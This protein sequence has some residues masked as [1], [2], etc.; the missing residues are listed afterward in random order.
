[1]AQKSKLSAELLRNNRDLVMRWYDEGRISFET[2]VKLFVLC[3]EWR[4][5]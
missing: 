5:A 4:E 2:A 3:P 1:M